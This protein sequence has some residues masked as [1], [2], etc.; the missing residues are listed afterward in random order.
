MIWLIS[1]SVTPQPGKQTTAKQ[2]LSN[3]SKRKG[4]QKM[5]IVQLIEYSMRNIF[6][7]TSCKKVV[8]KLAPELLLKNLNWTYLCINSLKFYTVC[9]Y[10]M[11]K[12]R[13]LKN[14]KLSCRSLAS[15]SKELF[16]KTKKGLKL[17]FLLYCMHDFRRKY[18]CCYILLTDQISLSG[19]L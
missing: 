17:V 10:C 15:T 5:K 18:F 2:I 13:P 3:I 19:C 7:E 1:K 8:K 12:W 16:Q 4:S 11:P 14:L 9:F 6:L